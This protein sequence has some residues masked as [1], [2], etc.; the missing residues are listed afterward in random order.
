MP[1]HDLPDAAGNEFELR[2]YL[3]VLKRRKLPIILVLFFVVVIAL[4]A[5]YV[6]TPVYSATA[7][8]LL[9]APS[10][11][12]LFD[13][14]GGVTADPTRAVQD[15]ILVIQ[16]EPVRN[17]VRAQIGSA[18]KVSAGPVGQTNAINVS[19]ESKD[20]AEAAKVA[21]AYV[22]AYIQYRRKQVVDDTLGAS[23]QIQAKI[24]D[25]QKQIDAAAPAQKD[26]L[27]SAQAVFKQKLDELQVGSAIRTGG[28]Q[29]VTSATV[30][31]A[32]VR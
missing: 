17:A 25:L 15:E 31:A 30:P 20:P 14:T 32:P 18:P 22:N 19:A 12:F 16:S 3:R 26:S 11:A 27:V 24:S 28:A 2:D 10:T 7:Q 8:V 23:Q 9:Q 1:L 6:Q 13:P 21:N 4:A 5:S 29:L